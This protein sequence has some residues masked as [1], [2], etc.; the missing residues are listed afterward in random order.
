MTLMNIEILSAYLSGGVL[1]ACAV[2]AIALHYYSMKAKRHFTRAEVR[3]KH[4]KKM[5]GEATAIVHSLKKK[6]HGKASVHQAE[7]RITKAISDL[8]TAV[9]ESDRAVAR[10]R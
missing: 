4:A 10:K 1:A 7:A 6:L 5:L 2:T 3:I 8:L 9:D